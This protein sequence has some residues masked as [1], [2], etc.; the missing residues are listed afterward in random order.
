MVMRDLKT[1]VSNP[2]LE[3][4]LL[5]ARAM[6]VSRSHLY[7]YPEQILSTQQLNLL[8]Q[9]LKRRLQGEPIAYILEEKEFWSLNLRV[10]PDTLIPRPETELLV[11]LVLHTLPKEISQNVVDLGTGSGAIALALAKERSK[12]HITATDQSPAAL[13][14]AQ[15]NAERLSLGNIEF[16]Q[17]TWCEAL[18]KHYYHAIVSNPPYIRQ[19]D[20]HLSQGDLRF[21][22][23]SALVSGRDGLDAISAIITQ[24]IHYLLPSGYLFL[25]HGFDQAVA[26]RQLLQQAGFLRVKS[27]RDLAGQ[28]RVTVGKR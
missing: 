27:Y 14:I 12:W 13:N 4:E 9:M 26:V 28:E 19:E 16:C 17:G 18:A 22:P 24:S 3:A 6:R 15:Q 25:E 10:T 7:A 1:Q 2:Q 23:Q 8:Q 20:P 11:E 21:E 5:L